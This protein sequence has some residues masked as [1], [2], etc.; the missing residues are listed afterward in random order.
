[1]E[2]T[3]RTEKEMDSNLNMQNTL[4]CN[5]SL[6]NACNWTHIFISCVSCQ[7]SA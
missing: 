7:K 4:R 3:R 2:Y 1:V 6:R 5:A